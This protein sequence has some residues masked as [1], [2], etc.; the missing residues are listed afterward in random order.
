LGSVAFLVV[1]VRL[2][3]AMIALRPGHN[4]DRERMI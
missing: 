3:K 4:L 1:F 2:V